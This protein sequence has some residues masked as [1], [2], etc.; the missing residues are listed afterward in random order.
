MASCKVS[1][2]GFGLVAG[3]EA[4][5]RLNKSMISLILQLVVFG[6]IP[7]ELGTEIGLFAISSALSRGCLPGAGTGGS[8]GWQLTLTKILRGAANCVSI[9][10]SRIFL[11]D[12]GRDV[13]GGRKRL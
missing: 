13:G 6:D 8:T 10:R 3:D 2:V 4:E 1:E 7:S 12:D 9:E 11:L 5:A